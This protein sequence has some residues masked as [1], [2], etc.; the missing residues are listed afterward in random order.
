MKI[1]GIDP[2]KKGAISVY[3]DGSISIYKVPLLKESEDLDAY[4]L[5][6]I[7]LGANR[8]VIEKV[9]SMPKQGVRS[10]F[11]FGEIF[12]S[13]KAV[14]RTLGI[15]PTLIIPQQ[16]KKKVIPNTLK[17]KDA[18][19]NFCK[20]TYKNV[21]LKFAKQRVENHNIAE[22]ICL[23]HYG[24]HYEE[25]NKVIEKPNKRRRNKKS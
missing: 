22:A 14:I 13:I 10:M 3:L 20:E 4:K 2:G 23:M 25:F 15:E 11:S 7:L 24:L 5:K 8:V 21:N 18:A 17:D 12:G 16:W 6:D 1:V 19:V 9:H